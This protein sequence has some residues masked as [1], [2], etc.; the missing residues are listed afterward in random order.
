[1]LAAH[2]QGKIMGHASVSLPPAAAIL[3]DQILDLEAA[4][5]IVFRC[6]YTCAHNSNEIP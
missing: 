6:R 2:S 1:M 3:L 4:F 5:G